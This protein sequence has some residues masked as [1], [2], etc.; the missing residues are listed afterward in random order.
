VWPWCFLL[1]SSGWALR[2]DGEWMLRAGVAMK[3]EEGLKS[4]EGDR[5]EDNHG[6]HNAKRKFGIL[7]QS[8]AFCIKVWHSVSKFGILYQS[9]ALCPK[10]LGIMS[11][12]GIVPAT[13]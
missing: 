6:E 3:M 1:A 11:I 9:L 4:D 8:L 13:I 5:L 7:Y 12:F 2:L 10:I